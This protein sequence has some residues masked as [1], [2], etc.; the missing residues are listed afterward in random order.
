MLK[1][2]PYLRRHTLGKVTMPILQ[3]MLARDIASLRAKAM[4]IREKPD[5]RQSNIASET[6]T[7]KFL[8]VLST[9]KARFNTDSIF[10]MR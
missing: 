5:Q 9:Y 2:L 10:I 6:S 7:S 4:K 1:L 3:R 8:L